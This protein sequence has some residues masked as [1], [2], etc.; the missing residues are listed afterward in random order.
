VVRDAD[1]IQAARDVASAL[2]ADD[3]ALAAE[4]DLAAAVRAL[5][6]TEAAEFLEKA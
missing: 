3:P 5:E 2:V 1:V 6:E 4:P